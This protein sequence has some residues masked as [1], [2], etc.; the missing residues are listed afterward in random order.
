MIIEKRRFIRHPTDIPIDCA[1][2]GARRV[3]R[4]RAMKDLS[5]GGLCFVSDL[6]TRPGETVDITIPVGPEPFVVRGRVV[7]CRPASNGFEIG[8][9]IMTDAD[10]FSVRMVEQICHIERYRASQRACGRRLTSQQAAM[11][12]IERFAAD[13]SPAKLQKSPD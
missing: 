3:R 5:H 4:K 10:G 12:W 13:F 6:E 9:A 11:E 7:W 2:T 8:V 1:A